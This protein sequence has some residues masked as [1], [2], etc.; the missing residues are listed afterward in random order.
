MIKEFFIRL[1]YR[2][3]GYR[4]GYDVRDGRQGSEWAEV[5][6]SFK[7][8]KRR[9]RVDLFWFHQRKQIWRVLYKS[10]HI[11][12]HHP[13]KNLVRPIKRRELV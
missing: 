7:K 2:L 3:Q 5:Y 9:Q 4:V 11:I 1:W 6:N 10:C 8:A 13:Y 12:Y